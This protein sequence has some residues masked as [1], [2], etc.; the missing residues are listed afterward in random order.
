MYF[1]E[2]DYSLNE[3][4]HFTEEDRRQFYIRREILRTIATHTCNDIYQM[5]IASF[6]LLLRICDDTQEWGRKN[7]TELYISSSRQYELNSVELRCS[8]ERKILCAIHER[9]VFPLKNG[10]SGT[11]QI[12]TDSLK[13]QIEQ[14]RR[15]LIISWFSGMDRIRLNEIFPL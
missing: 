8:P 14:F 13:N 12:D 11:D 6:P 7:I 2:S 5:Y 9:V 10:K 15:Q 3:D 1:L 4:Y